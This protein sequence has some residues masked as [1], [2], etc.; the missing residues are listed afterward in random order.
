MHIEPEIGLEGAS[1][2]KVLAVYP[3]REPRLNR[4]KAGA[5]ILL[6]R[7]AYKGVGNEEFGILDAYGEKSYWSPTNVS[8]ALLDAETATIESELKRIMG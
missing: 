5:G 1:K 8:S 3:R 7:K 4:D 2:T 6:L